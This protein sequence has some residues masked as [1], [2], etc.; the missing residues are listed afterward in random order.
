MKMLTVVIPTYNVEK[1][2]GDCLE[3]VKWAN[4][5]IVVDMGSSDDTLKICEK[6]HAK[7]IKNLPPHM[8]FD[9]NRKIGMEKADGEWILKIDSDERLLPSL[10]KEIQIL[11]RNKKSQKINGYN[12]YCRLFIFNKELKYGFK[13]P[14][15]HEMRLVKKNKW[16][17]EPFKFHQQIKVQGETS[18]LK[19]KYIHF[20][21]QSIS[22]FIQKMNEYTNLDSVRDLNTRKDVGFLHSIISP[23][24]MFLRLYILR[25]GF[26]DG[27]HGL[28]VTGLYSIYNFI[29]KIKIWEKR[30]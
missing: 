22:D 3:T 16:T 23:M 28:I 18:F 29:Y 7:I 9:I 24:H 15:F 5:I 25:F 17:Y 4:E 14:K 19:S 21:H 1:I 13:T 30:K 27:T 26:L 10:Q 11:L 12:L 2:I 8:N 20:N 6:Y